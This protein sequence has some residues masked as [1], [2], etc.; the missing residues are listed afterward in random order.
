MRCDKERFN[1]AFIV[2]HPTI[3]ISLS[4]S[5]GYST[6]MHFQ[7]ELKENDVTQVGLK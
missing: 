7:S 3:P 6:E 2:S 4:F 1:V 5:I